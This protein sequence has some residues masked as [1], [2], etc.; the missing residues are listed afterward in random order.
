MAN[1]LSRSK[2]ISP[3]P[4]DD[5]LETLTRNAQLL[6]PEK[7]K[8]CWKLN[9]CWLDKKTDSW[10]GPSNNLVLPEILKF[11]LLTTAHAL[12]H[13]STGKMTEFMNQYW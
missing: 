10:F 4:P 5:N 6:A 1:P 8:Q 3:H 12:S 7:E 13:W 2:G 11:P 9:N